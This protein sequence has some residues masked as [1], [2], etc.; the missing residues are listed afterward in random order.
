MDEEY[1]DGEIYEWTDKHASKE[2]A[3][4]KM[5]ENILILKYH[6]WYI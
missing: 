6:Y 1:M 2:Y 5:S 4:D 3:Y